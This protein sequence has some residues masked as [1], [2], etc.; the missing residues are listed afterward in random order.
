VLHAHRQTSAARRTGT[1]QHVHAEPSD[2]LWGEREAE[3]RA[4]KSRRF[5]STDVG[6]GRLST[7]VSEQNNAFFD[8]IYAAGKALGPTSD[9]P[10]HEA[11]KNG[12]CMLRQFPAHKLQTALS[13]PTD[14]CVQVCDDRFGEPMPII[15]VRSPNAARRASCG[16]A[17]RT[18]SELHRRRPLRLFTPTISSR[19]GWAATIDPELGHPFPVPCLLGS[20]QHGNGRRARTTSGPPPAL[21][22]CDPSESR[23]ERAHMGT[24]FTYIL[25]LLCQLLHDNG[26]C[27]AGT[28]SAHARRNSAICGAVILAWSMLTRAAMMPAHMKRIFRDALIGFGIGLV[29]MLA[30]SYGASSLGGSPP[31]AT[32]STS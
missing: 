26:R 30:I 1:V 32:T 21:P 31:A 28:S 19:T 11:V 5:W 22:A 15:H 13:C 10:A 16:G 9:G 25:L 14:K 4:R 8:F 7:A 2:L 27:T 17:R 20:P 23:R 24:I 29:A 6:A 3:L 18:P 12:V